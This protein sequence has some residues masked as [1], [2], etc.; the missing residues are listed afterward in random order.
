MSKK[1]KGEAVDLLPTV[2]TV[3]E[4]GVSL[5]KAKAEKVVA[6]PD[7]VDLEQILEENELKKGVGVKKK[8]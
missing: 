2:L 5:A 3:T 8:V 4:I 1:N 6:D 7:D